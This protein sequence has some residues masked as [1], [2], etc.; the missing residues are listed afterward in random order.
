MVVMNQPIISSDIVL[1]LL[2]NGWDAELSRDAVL[3]G[4]TVD[5]FSLFE[6]FCSIK[7]SDVVDLWLLGKIFLDE[8]VVKSDIVDEEA[9]AGGVDEERISRLRARA[10]EEEGR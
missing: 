8:G 4:A 2:I 6:A 5:A 10:F 1:R 3:R 9:Y 7:E